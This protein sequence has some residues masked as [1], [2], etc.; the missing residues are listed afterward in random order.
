MACRPEF[1]SQSA[2]RASGGK[3]KKMSEKT[4]LWPMILRRTLSAN[5]RPLM[6]ILSFKKLVVGDIGNAPDS[7]QSNA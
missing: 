4:S 2:P 1:H 5:L 6:R 7:I 3:W